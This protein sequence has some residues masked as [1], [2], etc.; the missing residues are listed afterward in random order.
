[1]MG[2]KSTA[3]ETAARRAGYPS[4][5]VTPRGI[6]WPQGFQRHLYSEQRKGKKSFCPAR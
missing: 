4:G 5:E 1:M 3:R 6:L 2:D